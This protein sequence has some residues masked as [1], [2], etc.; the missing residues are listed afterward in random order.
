MVTRLP[1][2]DSDG[3]LFLVVNAARKDVDYAALRQ[4]LPSAVRLEPRDDLALLALQGPQ[5]ALALARHAPDLGEPTFMSARAVRVAGVDGTV[6]RSGYTGEDGFEISLP[7]DA[8][9]AVAR[10]LLAEPKVAPIGLGARDS[11]RLEAG[12]C[13][14]GHDIDVTTTPVE[15]DLAFAVA[16]RRRAE[17]GFPGAGRILRELEAGTERKRVGL[18]LDGRAPAREGAAITTDKDRHIG[19]VTSGTFGPTVGTPIAMGY[20]ESAS[21]DV[22]QAL[23]VSV[24]GK[25]LPAT[26]VPMPFVPHHYFRKP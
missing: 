23:S 11:L 9:E 2:A 14:Y 19:K 6:F 12:L 1:E 20:V 5:A 7:G 8:A 21:A 4:R 16:R 24:R 13:L 26:V 17:G 10:A 15:A 25:S 3:V 22:G 18:R